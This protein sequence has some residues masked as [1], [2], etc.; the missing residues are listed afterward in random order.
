MSEFSLLVQEYYKN[1]V[2]NYQMKGC[3][4]FWHEG[5]SICEEDINV[6]VKYEILTK[7]ASSAEQNNHTNTQLPPDNYIIT[8]R[9][10]DGNVSMITQASSSFFSELV[11]WHTFAEILSRN[12]TLM[13]E[14]G[15]EV[16]PRRRR[17]RVIALL[18]TRNAIHHFL[19]DGK[20][21][22]FDDI[23]L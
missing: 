13:I 20:E 12:E 17:A 21:D 10:F 3:D 4:F 1:P 15:F 5:N 6:Y 11:V 9:S 2:N 23:L 7:D 18:A 14:N 8:K 22:T 19:K 16:S